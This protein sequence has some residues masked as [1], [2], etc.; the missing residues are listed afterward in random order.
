MAE[1]PSL[2]GLMRAIISKAKRDSVIAHPNA[3]W[4]GSVDVSSLLTRRTVDPRQYLT[5]VSYRH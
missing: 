2:K 4:G 3:E 5:V 1:Q